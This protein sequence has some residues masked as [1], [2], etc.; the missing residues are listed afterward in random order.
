MLQK[1]HHVVP[2][3]LNEGLVALARWVKR[4][5]GFVPLMTQLLKNSIFRVFFKVF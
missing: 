5:I 1:Q 3:P 2:D 4:I